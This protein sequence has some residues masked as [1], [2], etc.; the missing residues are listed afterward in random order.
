M[1]NFNTSNVINQLYKQE[2]Y[3]VD[4]YNFNTSNVIN[5]L[6][7]IVLM[8]LIKRY[9]NTSNVINQ[10]G[11]AILIGLFL[12]NFNTSNVINQHADSRTVSSVRN[13]SIH[14]M[15]LINRRRKYPQ[16][17]N[18]RISIHQMLLI[19]FINLGFLVLFF[20]FQYI[21]CY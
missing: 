18:N 21:K 4:T 17:R 2:M 10:P 13:I 20:L 12:L 16:C 9:F 1:K 5:Q 7:Q 8:D 3:F 14:Q 11:S 6:D 15:L 19:N